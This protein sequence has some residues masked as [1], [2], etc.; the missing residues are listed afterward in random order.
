MSVATL[1]PHSPVNFKM[2]FSEKPRSG[3][4]FLRR[5]KNSTH[6]YEVMFLC[7]VYFRNQLVPIWTRQ[8]EEN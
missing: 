6:M 2:I 1:I 3:S 5:Q 7:L 4:L 8:R